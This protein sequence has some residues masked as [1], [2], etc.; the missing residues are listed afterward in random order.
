MEVEATYNFENEV[1]IC[2]SMF[3]GS[4]FFFFSWYILHL[5][6]S[7]MPQGYVDLT[8]YLQNVRTVRKSIIFLKVCEMQKIRKSKN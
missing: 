3:M 4:I 2:T 8:M 6:E 5:T 7:S 1:S